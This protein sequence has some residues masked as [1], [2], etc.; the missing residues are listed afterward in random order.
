MDGC[1]LADGIVGV[2]TPWNEQGPAPELS[3]IITMSEVPNKRQVSELSNVKER[4]KIPD[5]LPSTATSLALFTLSLSIFIAFSGFVGSP[6]WK[7][8][9]AELSYSQSLW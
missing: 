6:R 9:N 5:Y 3:L 7:M 2:R 4:E 1:G 8:A